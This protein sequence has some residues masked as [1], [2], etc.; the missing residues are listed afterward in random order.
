MRQRTRG[1]GEIRAAIGKL[2]EVPEMEERLKV[3][4]EQAGLSGEAAMAVIG[5]EAK[6]L[7]EYR[8]VAVGWLEWVLGK[9]MPPC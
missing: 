2:R 8:S 5:V 4:T 7:Q 1:R 9:E 6:K 3:L